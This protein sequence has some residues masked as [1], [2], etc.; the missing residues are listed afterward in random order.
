[1]IN[2]LIVDDEQHAIDILV[3]YVT[4]TPFLRLSASTTNPIEALQIASEQKIDLVFLDIQMPELTGIDFI[5]AIR[6]KA[7]II[8]TTAYSEFALESY[9]LD[10]VDY[11]LKPIR[12][13]RFLQAVQ[14]V[15]KE[16]SEEEEDTAAED[17]Y[18]FV[19]TE[20]KGKLLKI[21]LADIDYIEGMKNYVAIHCG[22][23]KTLVYTSMKELEERLPHKS[24]LRVH[25]SFIVPVTKITGIEG[26]LLRLKAVTDEI[27][28]G[29]SY[30]AD[31]MEIIRG[32]MIQ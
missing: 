17:D 9:E 7:E 32:K 15:M 18:I 22:A 16:T 21:N 2:C 28:I 30:K 13:P 3:H 1:M 25:K 24:F 19:K 26:N 12:Y 29:E 23:K 27:L 10:V 4:Q 8:L 11:L 20:S 6:G 14:K 31:L 5:K